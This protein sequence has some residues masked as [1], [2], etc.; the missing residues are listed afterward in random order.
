A[1]LTR[2]TISD[3]AQA[4]RYELGERAWTRYLY[5]YCN[6][7]KATVHVNNSNIKKAADYFRLASDYSPDLTDQNSRSYYFYDAFFLWRE[8]KESFQDDYYYFLV[9]NDYKKKD[10]LK[11]LL[12]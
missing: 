11:V 10:I 3:P 4:N 12:D 1:R 2:K 8:N 5:A 6:Y 9:A 7:L